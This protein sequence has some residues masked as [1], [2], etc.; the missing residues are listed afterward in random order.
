MAWMKIEILEMLTCDT[1]DAIN[2]GRQN[3]M[4]MFLKCY[5]YILAYCVHINML[6]MVC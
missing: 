3:C 6:N 5:I 1:I 2:T 4:L